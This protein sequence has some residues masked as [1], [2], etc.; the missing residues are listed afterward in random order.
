MNW[1][2]ILE[3][4]AAIVVAFGGAGA[5]IA[6][7]TKFSVNQIADSLQKK[8]DL[9][10]NK[11]LEAFKNTLENKSYVS[12][13]R[14]DAEFAIYRQLSGITVTMVKEV[15]QLFPTFTRDT[16]D[17]YETYKGR[18]DTALEKAVAFQDE[19]A[20]SAPFIPAEIYSLFRDLEIK[21][22]QQLG[23]FVDF[24]LRPDSEE[25]IAECKDEYSP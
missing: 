16:R 21:C 10:L 20:G 22:K 18:Y 23:D 2:T 24:R 25:Y 5:I 11:E 14:F 8:Y 13:T 12:K 19:L 15:S 6:G 17:D 1:N 9:K 4:G 7:V 3:I